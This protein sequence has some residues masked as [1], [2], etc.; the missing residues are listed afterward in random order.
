MDLPYELHNDAWLARRAGEYVERERPKDRPFF[1]F[2]GF[3]DPHHPF[4]PCRELLELF[5]DAPVREPVDPEGE[6]MRAEVVAEACQRPA[7]RFAPEHAAELIRYTA[8]M[9]HGIDRAVGRMAEALERAGLAEETIIAFTSDHGDF[10]CDH[11]RLYKGTAASDALLRVPLVLRA[12]GAGLP[13]CIDTPVSN[14][15]VAPALLEL[16]GVS[17]PDG[18]DGKGFA[19]GREEDRLAFAFCASGRPR[20]TNFTV[21][22]ARYRYTW[23]PRA[24][25]E[26]LFDHHDD[27]AEVR[28]LAG[29]ASQKAH[30]GRLRAAIQEQLT[31]SYNPLLGRLAAY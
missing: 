4:T 20:T 23:Y 6:G 21:Y 17:V 10:L 2:V 25:Y 19:A 1:L 11:G 8:A 12:P 3:P 29:R 14:V 22:D 15:D 30:I 5:R 28:N 24:G 7:Q 9:V 26:E 31:R 18:L 13:A 27:P 16:A